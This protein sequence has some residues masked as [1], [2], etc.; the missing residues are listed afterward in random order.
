[1]N[2]IEE[3]LAIIKSEFT[4]E[5]TGHD[6]WHIVRVHKMAKQIAI[7]E[8]ADQLVTE[9]AAIFHDYADHKLF[10]MT[11]CEERYH[12][13]RVWMADRG[14]ADAQV[15]QVMFIIENSSYSK[16]KKSGIELTIE[17]KIVQDADRIEA[18]GAIG[19][20]RA[21]AYGGAKSRP[22]FD[23]PGRPENPDL[24]SKESTIYHFYE[25]LLLLKDSLNTTTA[26]HIAN[27]RHAFME[28]FLNQ[29][30]VEWEVALNESVNEPS[31]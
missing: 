9:L 3:A 10:T 24:M 23:L 17:G 27:E 28:Q 21:F 30:Y 14:V 25:K 5:P 8:H 31:S 11:Q 29:F 15:E 18:I 22:I 13:L 6:Y 20:A 16:S 7:E 12:Y 1:M 26:K 19:I 2:I 4:D